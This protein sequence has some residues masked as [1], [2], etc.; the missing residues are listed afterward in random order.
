MNGDKMSDIKPES[1][2][3]GGRFHCV[4]VIT[5]CCGIRRVEFDGNE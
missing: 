2:Y 1:R 4:L 3:L 5:D